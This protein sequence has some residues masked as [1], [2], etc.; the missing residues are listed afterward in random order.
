MEKV[1]CYVRVFG[2]SQLGGDRFPRQIGAS[3]A[4][5]GQ[6]G[7]K[8]AKIFREEA[9]SGSEETMNR[10][11]WAAMMDALLSNGVRTILAEKARRAFPFPACAG[12]DHRRADQAWLQ[13]GQRA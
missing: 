10:P 7:L 1:F 8:L 5:A 2:D 13:S 4:H 12:G 11:A 9:V 6:H 3:R